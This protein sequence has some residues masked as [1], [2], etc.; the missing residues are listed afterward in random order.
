[1]KE[2]E[3]VCFEVYKIFAGNKLNLFD[4]SEAIVFQNTHKQAARIKCATIG[5]NGLTKLLNGEKDED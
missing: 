5:W 4:Y 3:K 1:M 2:Y